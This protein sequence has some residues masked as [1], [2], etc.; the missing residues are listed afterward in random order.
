MAGA[1]SGATA[2]ATGT[3]TSPGPN[4]G[5]TAT[6]TYGSGSVATVTASAATAASVMG[7]FTANTST[8]QTA[9]IG[10]LTVHSVPGG[11]VTFTGE[12]AAGD[13]VTVGATTYT[14]ETTCSSGPA[15]V[16]RSGTTSTN[17]A[18]LAIAINGTCMSNHSDCD[19]TSG[20]NTSV[21]AANASGVV[22]LTSKASPPAAY[23]LSESAANTTV[24]TGARGTGSNT[25]T[26]F[27]IG[28]TNASSDTINDAASLAAAIAG[29]SG[30]AGATATSSGATVTVTSTTFGTGGNGKASTETLSNFTW[31]A[32][33][34][35]GG[36]APQSGDAFFAITN[37]TG[38]AL[39]LTSIA[40]NFATAVAAESHDVGVPVTTSPSAGVVTV[41]SSVPGALGNGVTLA[42][43]MTDFTWNHATLTGG[44]GQASIVAYHNLYSSCTAPVPSTFWS[45]FT[46][47]T[48]QTSPVLSLDGKQLAF[49]QS[50]SGGVASLVLLKWASASVTA[51][52][53]VT[54]TTST[55]SAY[56]A[57]VAPCMLTLT[58][59]GSH[60]DTNSSPYY[61]YSGDALYVGDDNGTLH[62]FTPVFGGGTP[63]EIITAPWPIALTNSA[64]MVSTSPVFAINNGIYIGTAR[65]SNTGTTGG[66][67]LPREPNDGSPDHLG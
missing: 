45:Y 50:S 37:S 28:V 60:N 53:P 48:V 10:S 13:T 40:S 8:G 19:V 63:A 32:T 57:C 42:E 34:L 29:N 44:V 66:L 43:S 41:T 14:F 15:C 58:F 33:T 65:T 27:V 17:G 47:G 5:D 39:S 59:N 18:N 31:T 26:N 20:A 25:G 64:G 52:S 30:T 46:G 16:V 55:A 23:T 67:F 61:D 51:G 36:A 6:L 4:D 24:A 12:P 22:T 56:P 9:T 54:L 38:T 3:F 2:T 35:M 62:K 11:Q 49:V 1:A 7:T 21:T